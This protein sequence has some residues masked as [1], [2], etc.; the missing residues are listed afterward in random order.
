[1][2]CSSLALFSRSLLCGNTLL[3]CC[4]I[5]LLHEKANSH[6]WGRVWELEKN[7][8]SDDG[9]EKH[10][11]LTQNAFYLFTFNLRRISD[12][13]FF[14]GVSTGATGVE[15]PA[16][17]PAGIWGPEPRSCG[18]AARGLLHWSQYTRNYKNN[19]TVPCSDSPFSRNGNKTYPNSSHHSTD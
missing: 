12:A 15:E 9:I 19:S 5:M 2:P 11:I 6:L 16:G 14:F 10:V 17:V 13:S 1:M 8:C 7:L 4:Y 3:Y 18:W